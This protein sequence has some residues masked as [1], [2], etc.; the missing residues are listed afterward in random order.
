M[1]RILKKQSAFFNLRVSIGLFIALLVAPAASF[2]Q[3]GVWTSVCSIGVI[4]EANAS[5]YAV[6]G[7][8][9]FFAAGRFGTIHARYNVVNTS[10][11]FGTQMP[12]WTT[13]EFGYFDD[14]LAGGL[15]AILYEDD[16]CTGGQ[17]SICA[18]YSF[19]SSTATCD[20]CTFPST[21]FD[22]EAHLYHVEVTISRSSGSLPKTT[23]NSLRLY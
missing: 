17:T 11:A 16:P 23:A 20:V 18:I 3:Q 8:S 1:K 9:L 14:S 2:A 10:N 19:D 5:Q 6:Q 22:F 13:F 21:T 12:A 15:T 4:D 7:P